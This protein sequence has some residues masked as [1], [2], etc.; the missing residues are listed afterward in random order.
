M[1]KEGILGLI[2]NGWQ[3]SG[4]FTAQSGIPA[5]IIM[6]GALL[7]APGNQQ[8]PNQSGDSEILGGIGS[9]QL[10]F[11]T[12]VFSAPPASTFGNATRNGT[13]INN[14]GYVN[15]DA[16]IVKKFEFGSRYLEFRADAFNA[17]NSLHAN[18]L[19]E[20][21]RTFGNAIFGQIT[22]ATDT[23]LVRFGLRFIF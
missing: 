17:T 10:W 9:G 8:R 23:R 21:A 7:R 1:Q 11:D 22:G 19:S 5:D 20:A 14:P 12:S 15:L 16:S 3:F 4:L 2:V 18:N 13:G 6:G